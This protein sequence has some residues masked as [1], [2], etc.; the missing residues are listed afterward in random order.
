MFRKFVTILL[1]SYRN[2]LKR[3]KISGFVINWKKFGQ[4]KLAKFTKIDSSVFIYHNFLWPI[5]FY[6]ELR[7]Y[8]W[9]KSFDYKININFIL[10]NLKYFLANIFRKGQIHF[11]SEHD[12]HSIGQVPI[13]RQ[14]FLLGTLGNICNFK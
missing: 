1:P 14:Y 8:F 9:V 3:E 12:S 2:E 10:K 13:L 7:T 4:K 11:S 6:Q 5:Y